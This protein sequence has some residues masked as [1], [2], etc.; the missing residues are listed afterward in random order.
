[1]QRC[2]LTYDALSP[3]DLNHRYSAHGLNLLS[4]RLTTLT[5]LHFCT[6]E[7]IQQAH[8]QGSCASLGGQ[9]P[10][11]TAQLSLEKQTF[12]LVTHND[13]YIL[14]VATDSHPEL[15]ANEDLTMKL[16]KRAGIETPLH[17][18]TYDSED[19]FV[20]FI[21]RFD[22]LGKKE[23]LF[24]EN[25]GSLLG[26]LPADYRQ[27][28]IENALQ[29]LDTHVTFPIP[30]RLKFLE[31]LLFG[32]LVGDKDQHLGK[33]LLIHD[34]GIMKLSPYFGSCNST[35]MLFQAVDEL[36]L[37]LNGKKK[38]LEKDDFYNHLAQKCLKLP[39]KTIDATWQ[40][41]QDCLPE[42]E[43]LIEKSFLTQNSKAAYTCLLRDRGRRLGLQC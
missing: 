8:D 40:K 28:S 4:S 23:R 9:K 20:Y 7:L 22:R 14:K 24:T 30:E 13:T 2:T 32:F 38:R 35:I 25:F 18:L 43:N 17:G 29:A 3:N 1:M 11:I 36:A 12:D 21:K 42:W 39:L 15:P 5:P 16:A 10:K 34:S 33:F 31:R 26:K 37:S 19:A 41:F 27:S 6:Q